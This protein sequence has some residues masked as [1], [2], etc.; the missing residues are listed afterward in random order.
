MEISFKLL[1]RKTT[2]TDLTIKAI[3]EIVF[4]LIIVFN[5]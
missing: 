2:F 4:N 5:N 3:L 1:K